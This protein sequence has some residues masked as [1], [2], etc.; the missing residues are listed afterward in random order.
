MLVYK[1]RTRTM[2]MGLE[3]RDVG[4]IPNPKGG[5]K[6]KGNGESRGKGGVR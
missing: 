5:C 6:S 2:E 3:T 4:S 1:T